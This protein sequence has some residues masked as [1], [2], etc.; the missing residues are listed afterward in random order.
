VSRTS[1][2][3]RFSDL[4]NPGGW[5]CFESAKD[6]RR[7]KPIPEDWHTKDEYSLAYYCARA[8]SVRGTTQDFAPSGK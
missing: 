6:R 7:L 1:G 3:F 8:E 4:L 5:L 2:A